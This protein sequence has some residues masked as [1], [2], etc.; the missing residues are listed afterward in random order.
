[1][2]DMFFSI[3]WNIKLFLAFFLLNCHFVI[4]VKPLILI[5]RSSESRCLSNVSSERNREFLS[6]GCLHL[7][8]R[9]DRSSDKHQYLLGSSAC[10]QPKFLLRVW[11][12]H[13]CNMTIHIE[14]VTSIT[15]W[16]LSLL[17]LQLQYSICNEEELMPRTT[18]YN[19]TSPRQTPPSIH[20][21]LVKI[22]A[23]SG[24]RPKLLWIVRTQ[25]IGL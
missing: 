16:L 19:L 24:A 22:A 17:Q 10:I 8:E 14:G 23:G 20:R 7:E 5:T 4:T 25:N 11:R 2:T 21:A 3:L 9:N 12:R 18:I 13:R 1:M 15:S 6:L